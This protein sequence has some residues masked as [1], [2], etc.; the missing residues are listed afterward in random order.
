MNVDLFAGVTSG[1]FASLLTHPLDVIK[2]RLQVADGSAARAA[3]SYPSTAAAVRTIVANEG[4]RG[5]WK[6][7]VPGAARPPLSLACFP[8]SF[9]LA[10]ASL[11]HL[12]PGACISFSMS[13][14]S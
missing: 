3:V 4:I 2:V 7:A 9:P 10:Q 13:V 14:R 5:L 12:Y 6:G 1:A 8:P 11:V